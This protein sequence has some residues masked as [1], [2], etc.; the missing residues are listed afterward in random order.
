MNFKI[1]GMTCASCVRHVEKALA[2][3]PG[4]TG[5]DVNLATET[6]TVSGDGLNPM[7]LIKAVEGA[8]YEAILDDGTGSGS[9]A[10]APVGESRTGACGSHCC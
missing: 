9:E 6:A 1:Q 2:T 8:G 7:A 5:A 4:V 3:V 10:G